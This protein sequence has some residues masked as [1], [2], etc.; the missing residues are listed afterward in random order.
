MDRHYNTIFLQQLDFNSTYLQEFSV[1]YIDSTRIV[2]RTH[3]AEN[4]PYENTMLELKYNHNIIFVVQIQGMY[5]KFI[6][7]Y[8][9]KSE[10]YLPQGHISLDNLSSLL[11]MW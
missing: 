8:I 5:K 9:H 3:S 1:N 6:L 11:V 2:V 4:V 10:L 7:P